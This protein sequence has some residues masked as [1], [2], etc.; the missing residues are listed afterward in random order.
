MTFEQYL[1]SAGMI[2]L[3]A[4]AIMMVLSYGV[5]MFVALNSPPTERAAWTAGIPY[6]VATLA[7]LFGGPTDLMLLSPFFAL[8]ALAVV[9]WFWRREYRKAWVDHPGLLAEDQQL[10]ND[11]WKSG[12]IKLVGLIVAA[13]IAALIRRSLHS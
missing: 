8:P 1:A 9:F 2:A 6:V 10:E 4:G 3:M 11:D 5:N 7:L 12:L 13:T